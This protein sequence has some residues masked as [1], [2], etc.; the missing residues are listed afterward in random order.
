M[1]QPLNEFHADAP[2]KAANCL[3][4]AEL[5]QASLLNKARTSKPNLSKTCLDS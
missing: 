5:T 2:N 3:E 4:R 1:P